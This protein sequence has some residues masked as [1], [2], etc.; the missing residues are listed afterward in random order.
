MKG[1]KMGNP[2][3]VLEETGKS[4]LSYG[5]NEK[6]ENTNDKDLLREPEAQYVCNPQGEH[7]LEDYYTLSTDQR[8][9]L[10]DGTFYEMA[11]PSVAHQIC[12]AELWRQLR[13]HIHDQGG[14]CRA[15]ISPMDVQLNCDDRTMVQPDVMVVCDKDKILRHCIYGAPDFVAEVLSELTAHRDLTVKLGKYISAGVKEYWIVD[16]TQEKVI[17]YTVTDGICHASVFGMRQPVPV[18]LF[19]RKCQIIFDE[20]REEVRIAEK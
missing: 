10:I 2:S 11:S 5:I 18:Q 8:M 14:S 3:G 19:N 15:L 20:I 13:E 6:K 9:E 1:Q 7:T 4:P 17:V 12:V 16:L